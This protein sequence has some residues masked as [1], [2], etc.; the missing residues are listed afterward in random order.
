MGSSDCL[1]LD[2]FE[3]VFAVSGGA[4]VADGFAGPAVLLG[5][6]AQGSD[7]VELLDDVA[8]MFGIGNEVVALL[9]DVRIGA[10][11]GARGTMEQDPAVRG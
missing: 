8:V 7:V 2:G 9:A 10:G 11:T 5:V 6:V 1:T 3:V 4:F